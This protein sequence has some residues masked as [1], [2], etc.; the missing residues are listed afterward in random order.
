MSQ[1]APPPAQPGEDAWRFI[2]E[3][4]EPLWDHHSWTKRDL[5]PGE[6]ALGKHITLAA[7]FPDPEGLLE[8]AYGDLEAFLA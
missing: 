3:L 8:T 7:D 1:F 2:D 6:A 5:R 4:K